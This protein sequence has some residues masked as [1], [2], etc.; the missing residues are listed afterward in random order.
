[1]AQCFISC[2]YGLFD[3]IYSFIYI[4]RVSLLSM[5]YLKS[6]AWRLVES[7]YSF[8]YIYRVSLLS[9]GYLKSGA[10]RLVESIYSFIYTGCPYGVCISIIVYIYRVSFMISGLQ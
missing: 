3:R 9:I 5:N 1:M 10:W 8:I 2:D 6:G 7:I 4:Y